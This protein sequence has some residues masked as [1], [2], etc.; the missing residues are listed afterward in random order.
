MDVLPIEQ[1]LY[2]QIYMYLFSGLELY[3]NTIGELWIQTHN[4]ISFQY[5]ILCILTLITQ[6][7]CTIGDVYFLC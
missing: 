7:C 3:V 1:L 4:E 5:D 2:Y 6:N